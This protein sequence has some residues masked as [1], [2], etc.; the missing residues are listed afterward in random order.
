MHDFPT[1]EAFDVSKVTGFL[2]TAV[3]LRR[4][5][6][7]VGLEAFEAVVDDLQPLL[8]AGRLRNLVD[9][10]PVP[11]LRPLAELPRTEAV[12]VLRRAYL[13]LAL[14]TQAYVWGKNNPICEVNI[15]TGFPIF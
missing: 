4:L 2:P 8:L 14:I 11:S 10:M 1:P 6:T 7:S 13:V 15:F 9:L 12:P 3:P 5:P